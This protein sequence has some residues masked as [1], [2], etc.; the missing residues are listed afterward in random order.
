MESSRRTLT[1][2]ARDAGDSNDSE[3]LLGVGA[4]EGEVGATDGLRVDDES[5]YGWGDALVGLS[6][7]YN[8]MGRWVADTVVVAVAEDVVATGAALGPPSSAK[9]RHSFSPAVQ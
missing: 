7:S 9:S 5:M 6:S 3:H 1:S 8:T 2:T 4:V